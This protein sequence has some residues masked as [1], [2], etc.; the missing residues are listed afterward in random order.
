MMVDSPNCPVCLREGI[1]EEVL[2]HA[3]MSQFECTACGTFL[4]TRRDAVNLRSSRL[5][6][7]WDGTKLSALL[8]EQTLVR[9]G[10]VWL[11]DKNE[12][13]A[14]LNRTDIVCITLQ[15]LLS[16]WPRTVP[17]RLER[18]LCNLARLSPRG[19][20]PVTVFPPEPPVAFAK[21]DD[22]A[23]F[24]LKGL[25]DYGF[26][27]VGS[28]AG[29]AGIVTV[30]VTPRGWAQFEKLTRGGSAPENPAFVAMWFGGMD[31]KSN[32][33]TAFREAIQPAIERAG[34]RATRVDLAEHNDWIMD[35][36]LG[37]IRL[38]PFVVADFTKHRN[39]VYF[40]AGFARGLGIPVIHTCRQGDFHEA[41]FDTTQLNHIVWST[42]QEL[43]ERLYNRIRGTIGQG[44]YPL[45]VMT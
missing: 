27:E 5:R 43:G 17:E 4:V 34:Y 7:A 42:P 13:Y 2:A 41:H 45:G 30:I 16:H 29:N 26:L 8:R 10:T 32:M 38:A 40:E 23:R 35:K 36:V 44:P 37:D 6:S 24:H 22:E 18:M 31:E 3:D 39:G 11:Q 33:D 25:I 9:S 19:G 14:P 15:E 20:Y 28:K 12:Q 21:T 1:K